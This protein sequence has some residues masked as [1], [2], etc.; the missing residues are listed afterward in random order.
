MRDRRPPS[1]PVTLAHATLIVALDLVLFYGWFVIA[2]PHQVFV[3]DQPE[4][5]TGRYVITGL[6]AGGIVSLVYLAMVLGLRLALHTRYNHPPS[7]EIFGYTLMP[8]IIIVFVTST[9]LSLGPFCLGWR[10]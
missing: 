4:H 1:V 6:V 8:V 5:L 10:A 3:L 9:M 7:P 2:D